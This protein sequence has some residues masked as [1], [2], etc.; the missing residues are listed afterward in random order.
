[1]YGRSDLADLLR[2]KY[3][4]TNSEAHTNCHNR[5][6]EESWSGECS[7]ERTSARASRP[8]FWNIDVHDHFVI[9][10]RNCCVFVCRWGGPTEPE[11]VP[12]RSLEDLRDYNRIHMHKNLYSLQTRIRLHIFERTLASRNRINLSGKG[13]EYVET[14][15][16]PD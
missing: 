15:G 10:E 1:M 6:E 16:I 12:H 4:C 11:H 2:V 9:Q 13:I 14:L 5:H 3:D 7:W 8:P